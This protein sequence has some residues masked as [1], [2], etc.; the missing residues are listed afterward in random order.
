VKYTSR[1]AELAT[2]T[3]SFEREQ[4]RKSF[5]SGRRQVVCVTRVKGVKRRGCFSVV[6]VF[7]APCHRQEQ[8]RE[9]SSAPPCH[10]HQWETGQQQ[11]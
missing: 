9:P 2:H 1:R 3:T 8:R 10:L 5:A 4:G 11:S 6:V 7:C